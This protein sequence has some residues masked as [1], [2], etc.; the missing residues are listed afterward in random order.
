VTACLAATGADGV[1]GRVETAGNADRNVRRGSARGRAT[2]RAAGGPGM[3]G[4]FGAASAGF[5]VDAR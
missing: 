5:E 4:P 3:R 1:F 2:S